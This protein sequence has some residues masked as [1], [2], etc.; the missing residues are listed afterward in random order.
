M[1]SLGVVATRFVRCRWLYLLLCVYLICIYFFSM[2][3]FVRL[4]CF[5]CRFLLII[6]DAHQTLTHK[7]TRTTNEYKV[8]TIQN[9]ETLTKK[10]SRRYLIGSKIIMIFLYTIQL[11]ICRLIETEFFFVDFFFLVAVYL[12]IWSLTYKLNETSF[13]YAY[14]QRTLNVCK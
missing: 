7:Q 10:T 2:F 3:F 11:F 14:L 9:N 5:A 4:C 13:K 1:I 12:R 8:F 6:F